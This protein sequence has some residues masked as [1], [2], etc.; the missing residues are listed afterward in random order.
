[1]AK[2]IIIDPGHGGTDPGA[3]GFGVREKDWNLRI[4]MYQ[5]ERL[6]ELGAKVAITRTSDV[7]LDPVPRTNKIKNKYDVCISNH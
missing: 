2:S 6:K 7:T 5:Y 3:I 1:M 4:S